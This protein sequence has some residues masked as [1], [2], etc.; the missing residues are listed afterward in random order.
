MQFTIPRDV[1]LPALATISRTAR[2]NSQMPQL[3]HIQITAKDGVIRLFATNLKWSVMQ[4]LPCA[5][6]FAAGQGAI[7]AKLV[8]DW[9]GEMPPDLINLTWTAANTGWYLQC[10]GF[11]AHLVGTDPENLPVAP[12]AGAEPL[13]TLPAAALRTGIE[14]VRYAAS[15]DINRSLSNILFHFHDGVL[16]LVGADGFR[17]VARTVIC[18]EQ[19]AESDGDLQLLV[20]AAIAAELADSLPDSKGQPVP[21]TVRITP[22]RNQMIFQAPGWEFSTRL[23]DG[24]YVDYRGFIAQ[25]QGGPIAVQLATADLIKALRIIENFAAD[26]NH[27]VV[28]DL[29]RPDDPNQPSLVQL[30]ASSERGSTQAVLEAVIEGAPIRIAFNTRFMREALGGINHATTMLRLRSAQQ[31]GS[32]LPATA[33]GSDQI[34]LLMPLSVPQIAAAPPVAATPPPPVAEANEP[35]LQP[36]AAPAAEPAEA[37]TPVPIPTKKGK[38]KRAAA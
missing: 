16:T 30:S 32:V 15:S 17:L 3:G 24:Q 7:P 27:C 22:N 38:P 18:E 6:I 8:T 20:P 33:T 5:A 28:F 31:P 14:A 19:L 25:N 9:V 23:A 2:P 34:A 37:P 12:V 4:E 21:V 13:T 10:Q 29:M 1:L 35:D 36:S 26:A 11:E